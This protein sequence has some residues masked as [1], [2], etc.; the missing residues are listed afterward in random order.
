MGVKVKLRDV[1][2]ELQIQG[3][4]GQAYLNL[5]TGEATTIS[6]EYLEAVE[7]GRDPAD[8]SGWEAEA[9]KE[10]KEA[11][12]SEDYLPLP[13]HFDLDSYAIMEAFCQAIEDP[14]LSETMVRKIRGSGAF[15][16]FKQ[17]IYDH[18]LVDQWHRYRDQAV[19]EIA[20]DWLEAHQIAYTKD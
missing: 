15:R 7:Q 1:V 4:H 17:A 13:S 3:N 8:Y 20:I 2:G 18:D 6:N 10:A 9:V 11:C 12:E 16:R 19:E 14:D 5:L